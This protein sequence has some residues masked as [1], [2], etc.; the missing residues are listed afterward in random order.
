[1]ITIKQYVS[2]AADLL[3]VGLMI[4]QLIKI[5]KLQMEKYEFKRYFRRFSLVVLIMSLLHLLRSYADVQMG[6]FTAEDFGS[7]FEAEN[8]FWLWTVVAAGTIDIFLSTVFISM[9]ITFLGWYLYEDKDFIRRKFWVGFTPLIISAAIAG[10][11]V[12]MAVMSKLGYWFFIVALCLFFIIRIAYLFIALWLLREYKKQNG[13]LRFFNPWVFFIPVFAGWLLQD[14]FD[15][16]FSAL[17]STVGLI[18]LY[19]SIV[20]E[21]R[22]MD[23][24]TGFYN[25]DFVGYLKELIRKKEYDPC[26]AMNFTLN[27]SG[28]MKDFS[29]ILKKQL[30]DNCEPIL[31]NDS[32][33]VVLTNVKERAPLTMVMED[34]KALFE[35]KTGCTLKKKAETTEEFMERV[36]NG[37]D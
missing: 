28:A 15:W 33:V 35:V 27:S 32:E 14:I 19:I 20:S 12:P 25:T 3:A 11:S 5:K 8:A 24:K 18:L 17:G 26:S 1:M 30:P 2:Y 16:G 21:Q 22:Y 10:F 31:C 13:Y 36:C 9:W 37:F 29:E 6:G 7:L 23:P 34:V 4:C